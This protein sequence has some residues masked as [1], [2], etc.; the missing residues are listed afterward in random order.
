MVELRACPF[1]GGAAEWREYDEAN[2]YQAFGLIA[3]HAK[4]CYLRL[5]Q[6][7]NRNWVDLWN[8]RPPAPEQF[9]ENANCSPDTRHQAQGEELVESFE[10]WEEIADDDDAVIQCGER[11]KAVAA[12]INCTLHGFNDGRTA[13]FVTPDGNVIEVGPKFRA[14][15]SAMPDVV[16]EVVAWLR[17]REKS[18]PLDLL[19]YGKIYADQIQAKWGKP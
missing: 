18:H 17:E 14:A 9:A 4:D 11:W 15:L 8:T 3:D 6:N 7:F 12:K 1:C 10:R 5:D 2:P 16:A 19:N 13:S